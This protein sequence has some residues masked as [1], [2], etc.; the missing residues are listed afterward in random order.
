M[1]RNLHPP[2]HCNAG[3]HRPLGMSSQVAAAAVSVGRPQVGLAGRGA[4]YSVRPLQK[5][6]PHVEVQKLSRRPTVRDRAAAASRKGRRKAATGSATDS[7]GA[8]L[9]SACVRVHVHL[10]LG[11]AQSGH[12]VSLPTCWPARRPERAR[13]CPPYARR[14]VGYGAAGC[15]ALQ[16]DF[17]RLPKGLLR[18]K[19][20]R[21]SKRREST[22]RR[23]RDFFPR[24]SARADDGGSGTRDNATGSA[25]SAGIPSGIDMAHSG[26]RG[27]CSLAARRAQVSQCTK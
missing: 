16:G 22:R 13:R 8:P 24:R 1:T 15:P 23:R 14:A 21:I 4:Y 9:S 26:L 25:G 5:K 7:E 12:S 19:G 17:T 3:P 6:F 11:C 20:T 18:V 27:A 2:A 10:S